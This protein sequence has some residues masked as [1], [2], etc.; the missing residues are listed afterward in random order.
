M[1]VKGY[2]FYRVTEVSEDMLRYDCAFHNPAFPLYVM[3]PQWYVRKSEPT[4]DRWRSFGIY[5]ERLPNTDIQVD[6]EAWETRI[7]ERGEYIPIPLA[8]WLEAKNENE[9]YRVIRSYREASRKK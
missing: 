9:A 6:P 7:E 8:V 5:L 3:Y 2:K 4:I 1:K